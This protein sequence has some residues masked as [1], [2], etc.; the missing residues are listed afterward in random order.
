[1]AHEKLVSI[2]WKNVSEITLC[3]SETLCFPFVNISVVFFYV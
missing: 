2:H 1:M 3:E